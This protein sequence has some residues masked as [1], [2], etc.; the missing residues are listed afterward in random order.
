M[1]RHHIWSFFDEREFFSQVTM[2]SKKDRKS[3]TISKIIGKFDC[4]LYIRA[5]KDG[6]TKTIFNAISF[7][8]TFCDECEI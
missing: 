1:V 6:L 5:Y 7:A 3:L 4:C 2:L 8:T